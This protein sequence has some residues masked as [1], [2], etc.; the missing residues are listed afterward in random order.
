V[1]IVVLAAPMAIRIVR[2]QIRRSEL[3]ARAEAQFGDTTRDVIRAVVP[4]LLI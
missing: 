1:V 2:Q 4:A 3:A